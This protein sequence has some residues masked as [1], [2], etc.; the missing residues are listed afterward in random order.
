MNKISVARFCVLA[1][2][3]L[4]CLEFSYKFTDFPQV[5]SSHDWK[6]LPIYIWDRISED[7]LEDNLGKEGNMPFFRDKR[8]TCKVLLRKHEAIRLVGKRTDGWECNIKMELWERI[9]ENVSRIHLSQ[10]SEERVVASCEHCNEPSH[11]LK[12]EILQ[13]LNSC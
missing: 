1:K 13:Y 4:W 11:F 6:F 7:N 3:N 9:W 2:V 12:W 5:L 8:N 10:D